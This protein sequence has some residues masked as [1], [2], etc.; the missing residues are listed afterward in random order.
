MPC[1]IQTNKYKKLTARVDLAR[2]IALLTC[3]T[4]CSKSPCAFWACSSTWSRVSPCCSTIIC[5]SSNNCANS[6]Y[7][8]FV[9]TYSKTRLGNEGGLQRLSFEFSWYHHVELLL[10]SRLPWLDLIYYFVS[11]TRQ[12]K[13]VRHV[14][15]THVMEILRFEQRFGFLDPNRWFR[16]IL[17]Q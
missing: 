13:M 1:L 17:H 5:I 16:P 12:K 2:T 9:G 14:S 4:P 8:I 6:Y 10:L 3:F 15:N 11:T 7:F